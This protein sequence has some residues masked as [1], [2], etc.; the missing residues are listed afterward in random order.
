MHVFGALATGSVGDR[1]KRVGVNRAS[2]IDR[3]TVMLDRYMTAN[4]N[5]LTDQSQKFASDSENLAG[6]SR[7]GDLIRRKI[8][9]PDLDWRYSDRALARRSGSI[10]MFPPFP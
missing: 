5:R 1:I 2:L 7:A 10:I 4:T 6:I 3:E 9:S 8:R